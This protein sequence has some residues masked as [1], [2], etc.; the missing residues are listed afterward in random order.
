MIFLKALFCVYCAARSVCR[1]RIFFIALIAGLLQSHSF[2]QDG[3]LFLSGTLPSLEE[4][5]S[6]KPLESAKYVWSF[7]SREAPSYE[8]CGNVQV[9]RVLRGL[10]FVKSTRRG[11]DGEVAAFLE[12]SYIIFGREIAG[13]NLAEGLDSFTLH[14]RMH[15]KWGHWRYP[16]LASLDE[17]LPPERRDI[18]T[19]PKSGQGVCFNWYSDSIEKLLDKSCLKNSRVKKLLSREDFSAGRISV[20]SN[21]RGMDLSWWHELTFVYDGV[22]LRL[23]I[24]GVLIAENYPLAAMQNLRAPFVFPAHS[25]YAAK[26]RKLEPAQEAAAGAEGASADSAAYSGSLSKRFEEGAKFFEGDLDIVAFWDR[27]LSEDEIYYL[28]ESPRA[29]ELLKMDY[30]GLNPESAYLLKSSSPDAAA[31]FPVPLYL[32]TDCHLFYVLEKI[33]GMDK[34]GLGGAVIEHAKTDELGIFHVLGRAADITD[35]FQNSNEYPDAVE[36]GGKTL[37]FHSDGGADASYAA[38]KFKGENI[39]ISESSDGESFSRRPKPAIRNSKAPFCVFEN[40]GT[41][42][43]FMSDGGIWAS[44]DS[45]SWKKLKRTWKDKDGDFPGWV[46]VFNIGG[47]WRMVGGD[48]RI[49][50]ADNPLGKWRPVA[51]IIVGGLKY[52]RVAVSATD[53][54]GISAQKAV[55]A[56]VAYRGSAATAIVTRDISLSENGVLKA[57]PPRALQPESGI[58]EPFG[59]VSDSG[60]PVGGKSGSFRLDGLS[61][62]ARAF[63]Q[64]AP[65]SLKARFNVRVEKLGKNAVFGVRMGAARSGPYT[66]ME[67]K[68][69]AADS[70][71]RLSEH[72]AAARDKE[73]GEI[74]KTAVSER[75]RVGFAKLS[76][77]GSFPVEILFSQRVADI[78]LND[79]TPIS[80]AGV[81]AVR[82]C[83]EFFAENCRVEISGLQMEPAGAVVPKGSA[84]PNAPKAQKRSSRFNR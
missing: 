41:L 34:W 28:S 18:I 71:A 65:L 30:V 5:E 26:E 75:A 32:G 63:A 74:T 14:L 60:K 84:R 48:G 72:Y 66:G 24:D 55:L 46:D 68:I 8:T 81:P 51:D 15:S 25:Y 49:F 12:G 57:S 6:S 2:S 42:Y 45:L 19:P 31:S 43:L 7:S 62:K 40:G 11:G 36:F 53:G 33:G 70:A 73:S 50:A 35:R 1:R 59:I 69:S 80:G 37:L 13:K 22:R 58:A 52:P 39:W 4:K 29:C 79:D 56:G 47:L 9:G 10:E 54:L 44:T 23:Y 76:E 67:L 64:P 61:K 83:A 38:S 82:D 27:A 20:S 78:Y 3:D 21:L 16:L 17:S 77:G